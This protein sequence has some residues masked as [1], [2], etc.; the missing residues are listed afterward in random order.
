MKSIKV[1]IIVLILSLVLISSVLTVGMGLRS[2]I[3]TTNDIVGALFSSQLDGAGRIFANFMKE[4]FGALSLNSEGQLMDDQGKSIEGRYDNLDIF[5]QDMDMVATIFGKTGDDF[6]RIIT[7][8][9]NDQG[10]RAIGTV[11]DQTGD[12]YEE[13]KKGNEYKGEALILG[14]NYV[15][16]YIPIFDGDKNVIGIYFVGTPIAE[17]N[18]MMKEGQ[19]ATIQAVIGVVLLILL[20]ASGMS[21]FIGNM[22]AKP[23]LTLTKVIQKQSSLDFSSGDQTEANKYMSRKDEIGTMTNAL[24]LMENNVRELLINTAHTADQVLVTTEELTATSQQTSRAAEEIAQTISEIANGATDQAE[25]TSVGSEKLMDLGKLI[26]ED[27]VQ[28][29]NLTSA[30]KIVSELVGQGLTVVDT[31]SNKTKA[32]GDVSK[33]VHSSIIKTNDSSSKIS[34]ASNL[35]TTIANQTNLLALNAAIEAARAGEAGKGFAVVA[36]E[37]RKLAEQ[38]NSTTKII[39]EMVKNLLQDATD[40]VEKIEEAG[41]IAKEQEESVKQ[42]EH[43]F[44]E[45]SSAMKNAGKVVEIINN[46]SVQMEERK[47][48]V[49]D[50]L[51]TLSAVA[52]ENAAGTEEAAAAIEE[53]TASIEEIANAT[54]GLSQLSLELQMLIKK[55]KV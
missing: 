46:T 47:D 44:N 55:F 27:Q 9:K 26:E 42:T 18:N 19:D 22:I 38:S 1:K 13:I 50:S 34:A 21:Y 16:K 43:K 53:Q 51:Q 35:I 24:N 3:K 37:I 20:I 25:S 14:K 39:D 6:K 10:E 52:E 15:T 41:V 12:V 8:I 32:N 31:L 4:E 7:N 28:I 40:A 11:L 29:H 17:V 54:E 45:I 30:I 49:L 2:S 36:D 5:T 33:I 48:E 23:I